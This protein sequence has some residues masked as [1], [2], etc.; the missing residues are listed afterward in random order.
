MKYTRY[1]LLIVVVL[2]VACSNV[3]EPTPTET[4]VPPTAPPAPTATTAPTDTPVPPPTDTPQPA[5]D[6][7]Y[8]DFN[9]A[10]AGFSISYP[11]S[12]FTNDQPFHIFT[13]NEALVD[14]LAEGEEGAVVLIIPLNAADY[15]GQTLL[16]ILADTLT[17]LAIS[18]DAEE[19]EPA[20]VVELNGQQAATTTLR[21]VNEFGNDL[22]A[23]YTVY[24][25][26]DRLLL[27]LSATTTTLLDQYA[28]IVATMR[29]SFRL[30]P[31]EAA[32]VTAP[33]VQLNS[34]V[35]ADG[36]FAFAHPHT[37]LVEAA[38][39]LYPDETAYVVASGDDLLDGLDVDESGSGLRIG[40]V[41]QQSFGL[42]SADDAVTALDAYTA[43]LG[44]PEVYE[45]IERPEMITVGGFTF[46][47]SDAFDEPQN[48]EN[49]VQLF[50]DNF[51][52]TQD[53]GASEAIM[54]TTINDLAAATARYRAEVEGAAL[55]VNY[56]AVT[57]DGQVTVAASTLPE[58]E[59]A[60]HLPVQAL[61][62][63]SIQ[64]GE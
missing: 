11:E 49:I 22:T 20:R 50:A 55:L 43:E 27:L 12:W 52:L 41:P 62:A 13:S 51:S 64:L 19:V 38:P 63:N 16:D 31:V 28:D 61:I 56:T 60:V 25:E 37:W 17:N 57:N 34:F 26:N 42:T 44:L 47:F 36:R 4:A 53:A 8:T 54:A 3:E 48:P 40:I 5:P 29:D 10:E 24:R 14:G 32:A 2:L 6:V 15:T 45:S 46:V 9:D 39:A 30:T 59:T 1:L 23:V 33:A 35:G 21:G 58:S 18:P 7:T